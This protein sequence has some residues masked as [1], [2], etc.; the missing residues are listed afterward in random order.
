MLWWC[1][2]VL[3]PSGIYAADGSA[4]TDQRGLLSR[5]P[6]HAA[7]GA[8][9]IDQNRVQVGGVTPGDAPGFP[10][11]IS[12]SGSYRLSG[13][14]TVNDLNTTAIQI[15]ADFVTLDLNGFSIAGPAICTAGTATTC[16]A[17][18]TGDGVLSGG[19]QAPV[20]RGVRILNGSV[21]GMGRIGIKLSGSGSVVERVTVDSNA[22]GGMSV[23][24]AVIQSAAT[25]NGSFGIIADTVRDSTAQQNSG[26]G[27]IL[28]INGGV[29]TGNVS[30]LNGG[31]GMA[32][33]FGTASSNTLFLNQAAGISASCP[34]S[35]VSNTIVTN[36]PASIKTSGDGCALANNGARP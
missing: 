32:V 30:A 23:A 12:Q 11:T 4:L 25:Q 15:T 18:G 26:D 19:D 3:V 13:N 28:G 2:L 5:G 6:S 14:L 1:V 34:S 8:V 31:F 9:Y 20:P 24:G 36:G 21:R 16:P 35:L 17:P 22:G 33:Q 29:A 7:D 10:V 27:I